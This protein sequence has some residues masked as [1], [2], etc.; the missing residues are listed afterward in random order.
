MAAALPS[1][2]EFNRQ[3]LNMARYTGPVCRI[4]RKEGEKLFLK[5]QRC[6]SEKCAYEKRPYSP[7]E[8]GQDMRRKEG[9][10]SLRLREKQKL[11]RSFGLLEGQ[12][13]RYFHQAE[14]K[15][16]ITGESL[17]QTLE[18]R[19]DNMV[20]RLGFA[21]SRRGA[22]QMVRHR[23]F[24]VN[25]KIVDVPSYQVRAGQIISVQEKS[26]Q[27]DIIHQAMKSAREDLSYLRLDKARMEG[28][29]LEIPKRADIPV[30]AQEQLIVELYSK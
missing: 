7:G 30:T 3:N 25:G 11:K 20:Y 18:C 14:K 24:L 22:R 15:K 29:L 21:P 2:E 26:K 17:L 8:H 1:G 6:Y 28:E 19:L 10:Y 12:F 13:R 4:C 23:H 27:L 5:G 9:G 16:G